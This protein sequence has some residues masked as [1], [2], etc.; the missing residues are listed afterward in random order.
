MKLHR[1][2]LIT[3]LTIS[4][5]PSSAQEDKKEPIANA[6]KVKELTI[7]RDA[8]VKQIKV[9]DQKRNQSIN[10]VSPETQEQLNNRQDSI[11]LDLR[12]QLVAIELEIK[13]L[14]PKKV[15]STIINQFNQ[16]QQ[17]LNTNSNPTKK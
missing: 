9:E 7:R 10:G 15:E 12:S 14:T 5:I 8:L 17:Q 2:I 1:L 13:E 4:A 11:C 6:V 3:L 16:L